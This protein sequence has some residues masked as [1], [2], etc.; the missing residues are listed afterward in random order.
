M[1]TKLTGI[2]PITNQAFLPLVN[3]NTTHLFFY[4]RPTF[5]SP[6]HDVIAE[7]TETWQN[8]ALESVG[9]MNNPQ[10]YLDSPHIGMK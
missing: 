1:A 3:V 6:P 8:R 9:S 2:T 5:R 7:P 4:E 10:S